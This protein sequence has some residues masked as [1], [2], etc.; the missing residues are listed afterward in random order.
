MRILLLFWAVGTATL[1]AQAT[2]EA[3]P[4]AARVATTT[5]P[6]AGLG[7]S[8]AGIVGSL[9]KALKPE[10]TEAVSATVKPS[11]TAAPAAPAGPTKVYEDIK[12]AEV[13]MEYGVLVD[14][15]GPP[16]LETASEDGHKSLTDS[17][18]DG[19][20]RIEIKDSKVRSITAVRPQSSV[21]VLPK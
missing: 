1:Y 5:A 13:G 19:S 20:T 14:R 12:K 2:V 6:A 10:K 3:G 18:K 21:F 16:S 7:K 15:F 9:D 17:G 8:L 4:G 11:A